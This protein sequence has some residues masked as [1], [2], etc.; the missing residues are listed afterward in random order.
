MCGEKSCINFMVKF[1]TTSDYWTFKALHGHITTWQ[2]L[3][4]VACLSFAC[5]THDVHPSVACGA[6]AGWILRQGRQ[7]PK[8]WLPTPSCFAAYQTLL[9]CTLGSES[10]PHPHP[11]PPT[12]PQEA[13]PGRL[14]KV[15]FIWEH[16]TNPTLYMHGNVPLSHEAVRR[17]LTSMLLFTVWSKE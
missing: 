11:P 17:W 10:P 14:N 16:F 13:L 7:G 5:D 4:K 2:P 6:K 8:C 12:P 1:F 9:H 15:G 3:W